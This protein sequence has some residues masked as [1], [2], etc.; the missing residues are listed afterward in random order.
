MDNITEIREQYADMLADFYDRVSSDML[1]HAKEWA[2]NQQYHEA[3][4]VLIKSRTFSEVAFDLRRPKA[5]RLENE[6]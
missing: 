6:Q 5:C 4:M 1:E 3:E 2:A